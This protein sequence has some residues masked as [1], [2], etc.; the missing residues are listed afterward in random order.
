[1]HFIQFLFYIGAYIGHVYRFGEAAAGAPVPLYFGF[2]SWH[3]VVLVDET[4]RKV[5]KANKQAVVLNTY[6]FLSSTF[7]SLKSTI[8]FITTIVV[9]IA[10]TVVF[11]HTP[12]AFSI[13]FYDYHAVRLRID[14]RDLRNK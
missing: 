5:I 4:K 10:M 14:K 11:N 13:S 3:F 9:I 1:M 12:T 7:V 2:L 6:A 8:V